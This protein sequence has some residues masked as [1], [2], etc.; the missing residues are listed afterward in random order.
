M[1]IFP[2]QV[3]LFSFLLLFILH[4]QQ[5]N[6]VRFL[7]NQTFGSSVRVLMSAFIVC[8]YH[9]WYKER[10]RVRGEKEIRSL[11]IPVHWCAMTYAHHA[12][13]SKMLRDEI[14]LAQIVIRHVL[15]QT[16][17]NRRCVRTLHSGTT[18]F[19]YFCYSNV[20]GV[21]INN[22]DTINV[23]RGSI[24]LFKFLMIFQLEHWRSIQYLL[25]K[26]LIT[27][28]LIHI[29]HMLYNNNC[30]TSQ[31]WII[32]WCSCM[33]H[34]CMCNSINCVCSCKTVVWF[35]CER[36]TLEYIVNRVFIFSA[37]YY[38]HTYGRMNVSIYVYAW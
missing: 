35:S 20:C 31:H 19:G 16:R 17:L 12:T 11:L 22:W 28:A 18:V 9:S 14:W 37:F 6:I 13:P 25:Q 5:K 7:Y 10:E 30:Q 23:L 36:C 27:F 3:C 34:I 15:Q 24:F 26:Y 21:Y 32:I 33:H 4:I 1:T 2:L 38:T 29:S 8:M